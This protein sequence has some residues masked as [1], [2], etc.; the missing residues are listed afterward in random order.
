MTW[1]KPT[2]VTRKFFFVDVARLVPVYQHFS[3][4]R[5]LLLQWVYQR[6][7][8]ERERRENAIAQVQSSTAPSGR[9]FAPKHRSPFSINKISAPLQSIERPIDQRALDTIQN[10]AEVSTYVSSHSPA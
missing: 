8:M 4:H 9:L 6:L 7:Q 5:L 1:P 10:V 2:E 3:R